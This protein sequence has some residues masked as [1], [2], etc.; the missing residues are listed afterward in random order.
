MTDLMRIVY[1]V[2]VESSGGGDRSF[3]TLPLEKELAAGDELAD[4]AGRAVIVTSARV[5][6]T[7]PDA[8][9]LLFGSASAR[10]VD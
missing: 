4:N 7:E 3:K 10:P 1:S 9:G 8:D 6:T 5:L 2:D